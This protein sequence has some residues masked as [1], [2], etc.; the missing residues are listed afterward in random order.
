MGDVWKWG[1]ATSG[2]SWRTTDD[3]RDNWKSMMSN[4]TVRGDISS[5]AGPGHWNDPDML[6]VG[7]VGW[8][9]DL[10][11]SHLTPDEQYTHISLWA[12]QAAP[13]L[14]GCDL[15]QLDP[16]TRG[17]LTNDEVID[18]DQDPLGKAAHQIPLKMS[19][20]IPLQLWSRPMED[21][22]VA[23]GVVNLSEQ[24]CIYPLF[25]DQLALK[26]PQVVRDVWRQKDLG[27][28]T[29]KFPSGPIPPHGVLLLRM[30]K[31]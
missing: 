27:T 21:G 19:E 10:H 30:R 9:P 16:F 31:A 15:T 7:K 12:L 8:G 3:I 24:P 22:S 11:S 17:L 5:Y 4:A 13:L 2:N 26:G 1:A 14:I 6:V 25:F 29:D 20:W 18:I 23:V 28:F